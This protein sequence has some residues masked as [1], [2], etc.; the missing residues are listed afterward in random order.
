M[1]NSE[2]PEEENS[3]SEGGSS[4]GEAFSGKMRF[5]K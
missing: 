1:M 5:E 2:G 4:S 3:V